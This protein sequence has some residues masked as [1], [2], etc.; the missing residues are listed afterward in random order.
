MAEGAE[1]REGRGDGGGGD[2]AEPGDTDPEEQ[3]VEPPQY[4]EYN[5]SD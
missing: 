1:G 5:S 2:S 3:G 4:L